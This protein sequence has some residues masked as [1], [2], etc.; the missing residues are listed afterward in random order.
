MFFG[1]AYLFYPTNWSATTLHRLLDLTFSY[2]LRNRIH[3]K[4]CRMQTHSSV[5]GAVFLTSRPHPVRHLWR[6]ASIIPKFTSMLSLV[7]L[8]SLR[9]PVAYGRAVI[10]AVTLLIF[11]QVLPVDVPSTNRQT[12]TRKKTRRFQMNC[13]QTRRDKN[14]Q[15]PIVAFCL[16]FMFW[17]IRSKQQPFRDYFLQQCFLHTRWNRGASLL[18]SDSQS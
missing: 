7:F 17:C 13:R 15:R 18:I 10:E 9:A 3:S 6:H 11:V 16:Q 5:R 4:C 2:L 1:S 8:C 14:A 12:G